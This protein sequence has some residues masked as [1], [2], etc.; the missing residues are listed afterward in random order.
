MKISPA[1]AINSNGSRR[2]VKFCM[3]G[4]LNTLVTLCTIFVCKSV[5]GVN[6]YLSN[7]LG[8]VLGVVNSYL[9]NRRWVFRS[10]GGFKGE[11]VR[12]AVGFLL[13]YS[14][15]LCAVYVLTTRVLD[16]VEVD[17]GVMVVSGYGF[18]TLIGCAVYTVS[19]FLFNH[20]VTFKTDSKNRL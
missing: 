7:G 6:E 10:H 15:Q 13:C 20:T 9:W 5:L 18:A 19:N 3:V 1:K 17:L 16:G 2:F 11:A 4:V 14:A 12:F 8:Y